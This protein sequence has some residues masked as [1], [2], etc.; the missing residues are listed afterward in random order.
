M[1]KVFNSLFVIIAAMVTFA[2]CAKQEID[3]PATPETKTVQFFANSIET[4]T[5]F[6]TPDGKTYPTLWTVN[7]EEVLVSMNLTSSDSYKITPSDDFK[8]ARFEAEI[9]DDETGSYTFYSV[10]PASANIQFNSSYKS[11]NLEIPTTQNPSPT[12][13]DEKAQIL[14]AKSIVY[15]QFPNSVELNYSHLTAYGKLSFINLSLGEGVEVNSVA[16]TAS[17]KFAYRYYFYPETGE[18]KENGSTNTITINTSA[19]SDIWFAC[20][21]VDLSGKTMDIV[22]NTN[23]GTYSKTITFTNGGNF[24]AG[25][26]AKFAVNMEG[27]SMVTPEVYVIVENTS[28]LTEGSKVIFVGDTYA[29]STNQKSS[30]RGAASVKLSDDKSTVSTPGADVQIFTIETGSEDGTIA[31]NT[32]SGYIYAASSSSNQLKT[33]TNLNA[34][35]SWKVTISDK[36]ASIVAQGTNSRNVI[37][38]NPNNG[39]PLFACY[40]STN[41]TGTLVSIYKLQGSGTVKEN[42]LEVSTN[43]IEVEDDATTASF[44]VNS[45]LEWTASSD[46][47]TISTEGNTVNVSFYKNEDE[48]EKTYTVTVSAAGVDPQVVTIT[49]AAYVDPNVVYEVTIAEF[50]ALTGNEIATYQLSGYV[51]E[52]YQAYSSQYNNISFYIED[53]TGKVLIFR[54]ECTDELGSSIKVGDQITVKGKPTMYNNNIQMAQGGTCIAYEAA[55]T[56]EVSPADITVDANVTTATFVLSCD[57]GYDITYPDGVVEVSEEH[58][59]ETGSSTYTVE[60]PANETT[61]PIKYVITVKADAEGFDVEKTVTITQKAAS[62]GG[63]EVLQKGDSYTYTFT[64]KQWSANGEKELS[65]LTWKLAGDGGYWGYDA[66]KGQQ[67]GSGNAP[68]KSMT[69]STSSYNG[70]VQKIVINTSGASSISG[71]FTVTVGGVQYGESTKLT[72]TATEYTFEVDEAEMKKGEIVFTYTQTSSKAIYIK[73]I[74]IN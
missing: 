54:M 72:K 61:A 37:R 22:I 2:G 50:N 60:F 4:K 36:V 74:S 33:Q 40:A 25:K 64:G 66:T 5:A 35:A 3:A 39:S 42:Y 56:L 43:A 30:N 58:S 65:D 16:L 24:E 15:D 6:G 1:K 26:I 48:E 53:E 13:V 29:L 20:A 34:N 38:Y 14:A 17:E 7:D 70:G 67:F 10:S 47:A 45:D 52:I 46:N 49:Q 18:F 31:F 59:N 57:K 73:S 55:P 69:L 12:S 27:I 32:G 19:I 23:K 44:T 51:T 9:T 68:Y 11:Y 8:T 63:G 21:P 28:D 41:T 62:Q 71:S